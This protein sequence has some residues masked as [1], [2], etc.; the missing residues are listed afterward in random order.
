MDDWERNLG[1]LI[2]DVA[3]LR[4]VAVD[5][6][7]RPHGVT[8]AQWWVLAYLFREDGLTQAELAKK[9]DL[10][11]VSLGGILDRLEVAGWIRREVDP[12]DRRAN[13]IWATDQVREVQREMRKTADKVNKFALK[14]ISREDRH[15][16]ID[17]LS[18]IKQNLVEWEVHRHE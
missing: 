7:M 5:E 9:L 4:G 16:L 3:R 14:G 1:F 17:L 15:Q 10:G 12:K 18:C 8:R 11:R 2:H 13:R 6:I